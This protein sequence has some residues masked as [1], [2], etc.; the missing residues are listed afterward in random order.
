MFKKPL[1]NSE[2]GEVAMSDLLCGV[3]IDAQRETLM[4]A[5]G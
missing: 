4:F 3:L 2:G 5:G 1:A